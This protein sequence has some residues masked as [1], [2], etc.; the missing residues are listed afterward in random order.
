MDLGRR[1][2]QRRLQM[3]LGARV[4][5]DLT[6]IMI[7]PVVL[8]IVSACVMH[9]WSLPY[10]LLVGNTEPN[11]SSVTNQVLGYLLSVAGWLLIPSVVGAVAGEAA[12]DILERYK[13]QPLRDL[14]EAARRDL[15]ET[16]GG[17]VPTY[18]D[19]EGLEDQAEPRASNTQP[20]DLGLNAGWKAFGCIAFLLVTV[21]VLAA[22]RRQRHLQ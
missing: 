22:R 15:L 18:V 21:R 8:V 16:D 1:I 9:S 4:L 2:R 11:A 5:M 3:S 6:V 13:G 7:L 12:S 17:G 20:G 14:V 10:N 19:A